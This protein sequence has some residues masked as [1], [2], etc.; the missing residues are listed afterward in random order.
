MGASV[1]TD[2]SEETTQIV[3]VSPRA[4]A[5]RPFVEADD[6]GVEIG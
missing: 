5:L 6:G 1:E 4:I 3:K 2:H